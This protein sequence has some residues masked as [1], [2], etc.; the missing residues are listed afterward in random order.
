MHVKVLLHPRV[1]VVW[2]PPH[3]TQLPADAAK[4]ATVLG[5]P[6]SSPENLRMEGNRWVL[7]EGMTQGVL[8]A[9]ALE[10]LPASWHRVICGVPFRHEGSP[11]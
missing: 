4:G 9:R 2:R 1:T 10:L 5:L 8:R 6:C 11:G 7:Q 3:H